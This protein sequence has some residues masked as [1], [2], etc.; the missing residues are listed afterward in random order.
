M[1]DQ[2][3]I[4]VA[5]LLF[6]GV[7]AQ[8]VA[9][10]YEVLRF[11]PGAD[12]VFVASQRGPK[13]GE[14]GGLGLVAE[15]SLEEVPRPEI[16]VVPGGAGELRAREDQAVGAWLREAHAHSTWTTSVCTGSLLLGAFGI[17]R[18]K[19]ATTHWTALRELAQFGATAVSERYVFDGKL[20]TAAGV[21]AGI[22]MA[23]ALAARI[24]GPEVAQAIQLAIE[25]DPAPPF[26]A[27][28]PAKCP[29]AIVERLRA[30][31]RFATA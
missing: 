3:R 26:D 21:S 24:A 5:I 11:L 22:D 30:A 7:N 20:V 23:L 9:G 17:L 4:Q 27:G 14:R 18:D 16:I 31:S 19:R 12:V 28:S 25:Y 10:P 2:K 15:R 1:T 6:E 13:H 8:D 29:P